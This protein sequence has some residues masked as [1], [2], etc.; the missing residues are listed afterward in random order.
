MIS[1]RTFKSVGFVVWV[2][3]ISAKL[4]KIRKY[5]RL[6]MEGSVSHLLVIAIVELDHKAMETCSDER[7]SELAR[8]QLEEQGEGREGLA[9]KYFFFEDGDSE[10]RT[11]EKTL[12]NRYMQAH[13]IMKK[14]NWKTFK[15][16]KP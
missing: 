1:W 8:T 4:M 13:P 11:K 3:A 14:L 9:S 16:V 5:N 15:R 10:E 2:A 7:A 12:K 6:H